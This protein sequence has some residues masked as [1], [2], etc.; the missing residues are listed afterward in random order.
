MRNG[1][2]GTLVYVVDPSD[3]WKQRRA[4]DV[5]DSLHRLRGGALSVQVLNEFYVESTRRS[6]PP[7]TPA[8]AESLIEIYA[9]EWPVLDLTP[10]ITPEAIRGVRIHQLPFWDALLWAAARLNGIRTLLTE[11]GPTGAVIE[12]VRWV[13]PFAQGFS[14]AAL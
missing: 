13:N 1:S 5:L 4:V 9:R 7:L 10:Q 12:G 2:I 11:A 8:E 14:L 6:V 3:A